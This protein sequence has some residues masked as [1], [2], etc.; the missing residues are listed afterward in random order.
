MLGACRPWPQTHAPVNGPVIGH[1]A[2]PAARLRLQTM[3]VVMWV[4][5]WLVRNGPRRPTTTT[6]FH[7]VSQLTT[8]ANFHWHGYPRL[9][10]TVG[11]GGLLR[12]QDARHYPRRSSRPQK[13]NV[14]PTTSCPKLHCKPGL[15]HAIAWS[16]SRGQPPHPAMFGDLA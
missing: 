10:D 15:G 12:V 1:G 7:Q 16:P 4:V 11:I 6:D 13:C 5:A 2:S 3:A 14:A 9:S 8:Q